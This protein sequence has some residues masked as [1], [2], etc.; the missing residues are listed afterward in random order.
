M[1]VFADVN[2]GQLPELG[3]VQRLV[4]CALIDRGFA[5][6]TKR[7]LIRTLVFRSERNTGCQWNL[8]ADNAVSAKK[9][10]FLVEH[11]HR[12]A[13]ALRASAG[14]AEEL[15]HDRLGSHALGDRMRMLAITGEHVIVLADGRDRANGHGFLTNVE[16]AEAANLT[17]AIRFRGF[18][19]EAT[20]Q[21]HLVIDVHQRFAIQSRDTTFLRL[22]N[23]LGAP[24][25]VSAE[26]ATSTEL[27]IH[28]AGRALVVC[29]ARVTAPACVFS[30][31]I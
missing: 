4:K 19:F 23:L 1:I 9:V 14:F 25:E 20:D 12:A 27:L 29:S 3:H 15:G 7:N 10:H 5:K 26:S 6:E 22:L 24:A 17:G 2:A 30:F 8:P 31:R 13:L 16:M 18:F 11:V 28:H 21:K